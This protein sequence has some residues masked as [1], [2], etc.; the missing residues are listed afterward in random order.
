MKKFLMILILSLWA[1][2]GVF[3]QDGYVDDLYR[4][5]TRKSRKAE[6]QAVK[7]QEQTR[8]QAQQMPVNWTPA[9]SSPTAVQPSSGQSELVTNY[10]EALQRRIEAY[11][12][13]REMDDSYW[14]LME[15]YH[16]MLSNKYDPDLYN[17]ITFGNEMWVEPVY[18]SALF[19]GSDPAAGIRD[20]KLVLPQQ[21]RSNVTVNLNLGFGP[22]WWWDDP[23]DYYWYLPWRNPW[24]WGY[25]G[26]YG[27]YYGPYWGPSW[28]WRPY[29]SWGPSW[30]WGPGYYPPY[31]GGGWHDPYHGRPVIWGNDR[32]GWRPAPGYRPGGGDPGYRP[33][34]PSGRPAY[35]GGYR[36]N[37]NG[38]GVSINSGS[39]AVNRR[40]GGTL[41]PGSSGNQY[42]PAASSRP[43]VTGGNTGTSSGSTIDRSYRR[44]TTVTPAPRRE[45]PVRTQT[46][47]RSEPSYSAPS[48]GSSGGSVGGGGYRRR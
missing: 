1:V 25:Y 43:T 10:D 2:A 31:W 22:G 20:L 7:V 36:R 13:Y 40:P 38:T 3:A 26:W 4:G 47:Q 9:Q 29:W 27:P 19:D 44:E 45:T 39:G 28:G 35:S 14:Q 33:G 8:T 34:G 17:I 16:R 48:R 6:S 5:S 42:N 46:P 30:G 18:I 41:R 12:S 21:N 23:W 24:G 11:K 15:N 32:P 37:E